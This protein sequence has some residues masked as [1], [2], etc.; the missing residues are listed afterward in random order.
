MASKASDQ[1]GCKIKRQ[2]M[3]DRE[4]PNVWLSRTKHCQIYKLPWQSLNKTLLLYEISCKDNLV[5]QTKVTT[6]IVHSSDHN[7][8]T[9]CS[10]KKDKHPVNF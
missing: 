4:F 10:G 7:C 3:R 9:L 6:K 1:N 2:L 8:A 5:L